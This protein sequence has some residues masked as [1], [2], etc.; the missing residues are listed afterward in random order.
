[1]NSYIP[2]TQ[3][4]LANGRGSRSSRFRNTKGTQT[5]AWLDDRERTTG[6]ETAS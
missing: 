5:G 3:D 4:M 6:S 2:E 1:M